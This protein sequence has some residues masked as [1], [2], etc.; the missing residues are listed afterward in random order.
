VSLRLV[1]H[2][3]VQGEIVQGHDWYE[4]QRAGLGDEFVAEVEEVLAEITTN[5]ARYGF[6]D[7]DVR[8]GLLTRF[9]Y[10]VYY[11]VLSGRIRVL[12]VFHTARNP[13]GWQSRS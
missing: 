2:P 9:P 12:S 6:A 8:E 3:E 1:F 4:E 10:A 5:P 11:R 7:R 13:S